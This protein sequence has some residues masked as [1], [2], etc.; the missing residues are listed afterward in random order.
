MPPSE[1]RLEPLGGRDREVISTV[2]R[3]YLYAH[4]STELVEAHRDLSHGELKHV[5]DQRRVRRQG[6]PHGESVA[7]RDHGKARAEEDAV[8]EVA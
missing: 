5:E 1:S 3:D 4:W 2:G 6:A 8:A 7:W